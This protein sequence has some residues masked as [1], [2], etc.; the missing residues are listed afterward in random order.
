MAEKMTGKHVESLRGHSIH[1]W[2]GA[3]IDAGTVKPF[4][5]APNGSFD[6]KR[7]ATLEDA[8]AFITAQ[9]TLVKVRASFEAYVPVAATEE[10]IEEWIRFELHADGS[11][12]GR[13]P[14]S[15]H[16]LEAIEASIDDIVEVDR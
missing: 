5:S 3:D 10:Q 6:W 9:P 12:S 8:R 7:H 4:T 11:I 2:S 13:N 15:R 16:G 1:V 14:L